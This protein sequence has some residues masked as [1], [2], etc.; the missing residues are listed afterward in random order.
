MNCSAESG[1]GKAKRN[2]TSRKCAEEEKGVGN[3]IG[4]G[5]VA[6]CKEPPSPN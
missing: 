5:E 1:D 3:Y 6:T 4:A 2:E